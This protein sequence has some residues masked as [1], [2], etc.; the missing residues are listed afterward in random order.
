MKHAVIISWHAAPNLVAMPNQD[1]MLLFWAEPLAETLLAEGWRVTLLVPLAEAAPAEPMGTPLARGC[2]ALGMGV[3]FASG[4]DWLA[5]AV[6]VDGAL[7]SLA[8]DAI[9]APERE[10]VLAVALSR[11]AAGLAHQAATITLHARGPTLFRLEEESRFLRDA[12]T[13]AIDEAE[14]Q[15]MRLADQVVT[16]SADVA[17]FI[18][19]RGPAPAVTCTEPAPAAQPAV[20][21]GIQEQVIPLPLCSEAGLEFAVAAL[22]RAAARA[23]FPLPVTFLGE[24]GRVTLGDA[25]QALLPLSAKPG[26]IDWRILPAGGFA[27]IRRVLS[28]PGV[29]V[30]IGANRAAPAELLAL[31]GATGVPVLANSSLVTQAAARRW[32]GMVHLL[33]RAERAV[34]ALLAKLPVLPAQVLPAQVPPPPAP[35]AAV[36]QRAPPA[37]T[38]AGLTVFAPATPAMLASLA[39]QTSDD[40]A[41][42]LLPMA[43]APAALPPGA[44]QVL[45]TL[46]D[47]LA[48][49]TTR[50]AVLTGDARRLHPRALAALSAMALACGA[51]AITA[52]D[53]ATRPIGGAEDL[54]LLQPGNSLGHV[55]LLDLP[56]LRAAGGESLR[57]AGTPAM[58]RA[59]MRDT[60]G[61]TALHAVLADADAPPAPPPRPM[62]MLTAP[63]AGATR[64]ALGFAEVLKGDEL[65]SA[66]RGTTHYFKLLG[67]RLD[68]LGAHHAARDAWAQYLALHTED[69]E[70]QDRHA[71]LCM[72]LE[73]RLPDV[74]A[75]A[76]FVGRYGIGVLSE[77]PDAAWAAVE[78]R[79]QESGAHA[80]LAMLAALAPVLA[81]HARYPRILATL[82][83]HLPA[84]VQVRA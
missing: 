2:E 59:L 79:R 31:C 63:L 52:W 24:P 55:L 65:A 27:T 78:R 77:L 6:A 56:A 14:R 26:H 8:P 72:Q 9:H 18:A 47:A 71:T 1:R 67:R 30:F 21:G 10:A 42:A 76:E 23:P 33:P 19:A 40:H 81:T 61:I 43:G 84:A 11:R 54:A 60:G 57:A 29:A 39:A 51:A 3:A 50:F 25:A 80:A 74:P 15:A 83:G 13:L 64:L 37:P 12:E 34:S 36:V 38:A 35:F 41:T 58:A 22:A 4:A 44:T 66:N 75:L 32:P 20:P 70:A 46:P 69:G 45:G 5:R 16:T 62:D 73:S 49:C 48:A 17:A 82:R 7:E 28:R 68:G 53:S